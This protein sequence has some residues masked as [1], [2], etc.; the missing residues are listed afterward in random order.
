MVAKCWFQASYLPSFP[1][2]Y[3]LGFFG[4]LVAFCIVSNARAKLQRLHVLQ[5]SWVFHTIWLAATHM[6]VQLMGLIRVVASS[7]SNTNGVQVMASHCKILL[8]YL[9]Y[10][11]AVRLC[12][13]FCLD[14]AVELHNYMSCNWRPCLLNS[15]RI[16]SR[17]CN[18]KF[19]L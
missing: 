11:L 3:H 18:K 4:I 15:S 16:C 17:Q 10:V 8:C 1:S 5:H 6:A 13:N 19:N 12:C 14:L 7:S 2:L 9:F